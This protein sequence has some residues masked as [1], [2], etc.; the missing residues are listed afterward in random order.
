[1]DLKSVLGGIT[2][3]REINSK[4]LENE[5]PIDRILTPRDAFE[6]GVSLVWLYD[7]D[8]NGV[9]IK[10]IDHQF[11][12]TIGRVLHSR[13]LEGGGLEVTLERASGEVSRAEKPVEKPAPEPKRSIKM[14]KPVSSPP[15][16]AEPPSKK[17][18]SPKRVKTP[19]TFK[20]ENLEANIANYETPSLDSLLQQQVVKPRE[21]IF[22]K[23]QLI[24]F[25]M[26][27]YYPIIL[28]M[29]DDPVLKELIENL[30]HPNDPDMETEEQTFDVFQLGI[31]DPA[32]EGPDVVE[33]MC[34]LNLDDF[35]NWHE[36]LPETNLRPSEPYENLGDEVHNEE[37]IVT[38]VASILKTAMESIY[39]Y[40]TRSNFHTE[41]DDIC[42]TYLA[43]EIP[44][45]TSDDIELPVSKIDEVRDL[46]IELNGGH[47]SDLPQVSRCSGFKLLVAFIY[48]IMSR[49]RRPSAPPEIVEISDADLDNLRSLADEMESAIH[50]PLFVK[51]QNEENQSNE[52]VSKL[53]RGDNKVVVKP[54]KMP[55]RTG[56]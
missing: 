14:V 12:D 22:E 44:V 29:Q 3:K 47:E 10:Q 40:L 48:S 42:P 17:P 16:V 36:V 43:E 52:L 54:I 9:A 46:V 51:T 23:F 31:I 1:M 38:P 25:R 37:V 49:F 8:G 33:V 39:E 50:Q 13:I 34:V 41:I 27:K 6:L 53:L 30:P 24:T 55:T 2:K 19:S 7:I 32:S 5:F 35:I 45:I 28:H 21:V 20:P 18:V 26:S 4:Y 15:K 11:A 56:K